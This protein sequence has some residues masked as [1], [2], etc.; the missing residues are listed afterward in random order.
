MMPTLA[1]GERLVVTA[2]R[3][4][5]VGDLVVVVDPEHLGRLL[6]KRVGALGTDDLTVIGDNAGASRDSRVFGAVP[7]SAVL[8]VARYRY[9]P[10]AAA[11]HL[12]RPP[13]PPRRRRP[14]SPV[15][16]R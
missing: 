8:G 12:R 2:V 10:R 6:V 1:P 13:R 11:G 3:H 9:H 16:S 5:R 15:R 14:P 4:L 7:L